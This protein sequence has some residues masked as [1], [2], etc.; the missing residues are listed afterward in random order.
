VGELAV[1]E[2]IISKWILELPIVT[3]GNGFYPVKTASGW[4]S[5]ETSLSLQAVP[6]G[7]NYRNLGLFLIV[8]YREF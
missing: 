5:R 4:N 7:F 3:V 2:R 6:H 8:F 1:D